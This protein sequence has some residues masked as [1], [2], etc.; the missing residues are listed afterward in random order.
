MQ[1]LYTLEIACFS[2]AGMQVAIANGAHRIELC[3]NP[4]EGGTTPSYGT[5]VMARQLA[6]TIPVFPIIRPRG[7]HFYY[8][9]QEVAAMLQDVML[10]KKLG[11][12]GVV[13]GA[14]HNNGTVDV[15][16][17]RRLVEAAYPMEVTFHRAFDR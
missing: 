6:G 15:A 1:S 7:G 5:L 14:L 3:E 9:K 11:F 17:T 10:C 12:E 2:L 8:D 16:T 4:A 13:L